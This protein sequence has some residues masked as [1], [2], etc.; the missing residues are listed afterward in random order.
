MRQI[1][2][3]SLWI[4]HVAD[5]R[6][7]RRVL[8]AGIEALVDLEIMELPPALTRELVYCRIPLLDGVGNADWKLRAVIE[9]TARLLSA[10][11]PTLVFCGFGM[12]RSPCIA[13]GAIA[14]ARSIP[15]EDAFTLVVAGHPADISPGL[16]ADVRRIVLANS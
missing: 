9:T 1:A 16:V 13:A 6:E 5:A 4:G 8:D 14:L 2:Q 7:L 12:S 11:I 15:F 10:G 3:T